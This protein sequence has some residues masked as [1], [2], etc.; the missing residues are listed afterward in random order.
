MYKTLALCL[1]KKFIKLNLVPAEKEPVYSYGFE[2]ILSMIV[3]ALIF[4]ITAIITSTLVTSLIFFIGF[5]LIRKFCGGYHASTY[6]KCHFMSVLV[7]L[8]AIAFLRLFPQSLFYEFTIISLLISCVF[9]LLFAP[10]DHKNKPFIKN[11]FQRF[12][13]KSCIYCGLISVIIL[14]TLI[15]KARLGDNI[16]LFSYSLGTLSATL[17]MLGAKIINYYERRSAKWRIVFLRLLQKR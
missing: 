9:I 11:E 3:Y 17:S 8:V 4:V 14:L 16:Y 7:H 5:Y 2:I 1:T 10:V 13:K 15:L 6:L 12:R